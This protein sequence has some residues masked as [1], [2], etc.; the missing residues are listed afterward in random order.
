MMRPF[1][2][3]CAVLV[4]ALMAAGAG[5][6]PLVLMT[7]DYPPFNMRG[8][9]GRVAGLSTDIVR[10]LMRDAGEPYSLDLMPWA[11]AMEKARA[12]PGHCVF[13]MSRLEN[14]EKL[15]SWIGPIAINDFTLFTKGAAG[16]RLRSLKQIK[17]ARIGS[18]LGDGGVAYLRNEG[19][20]VDVAPRDDL[21][22]RK[23]LVGRI[24]YWATGKLSGQYL[25]NHQKIDGVVPVLTMEQGSMYLACH[26]ALPEKRVRAMN[27]ALVRLR[28]NGGVARIY[29][30]YGYTP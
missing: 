21:N 23:L 9:D 1:F 28:K 10:A 22:P 5:A 3:G 30:R 6:A 4:G 2:T 19:F 20:K 25:L 18:Y 14:R 17:G 24:D 16:T 29:A 7:E 27:A 12:S 15:F 11:R 26:R 8:K 13:S